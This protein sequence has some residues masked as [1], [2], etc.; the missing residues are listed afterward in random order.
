MKKINF[1]LWLA[2]ALCVMNVFSACD[3]NKEEED[4]TLSL[5][6]YV[7]INITRCE[8]VGERIVV[9]FN[10][11]NKSGAAI[12]SMYLQPSSLT[13]NLGKEYSTYDNIGMRIKGALQRPYELGPLNFQKDETKQFE[14]IAAGFDAG[15]TAKSIALTITGTIKDV[16]LENEKVKVSAKVVDN[17][18]LNNGIQTNDAGVVWTL[19]SCKRED[20]FLYVTYDIKNNTGS[21]FNTVDLQEANYMIKGYSFVAMDDLGQTYGNLKHVIKGS[22]NYNYWLSFGLA[23]GETKTIVTRI[24]NFDNSGNAT[25]ISICNTLTCDSYLFSDP[26]VRLINIPIQ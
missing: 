24:A 22:D 7:D 2:A 9:E 12:S 23:K 15:N 5:A 19:K 25:K 14:V 21:Q 3:K 18:V 26:I 17:R 4:N 16:D 11:R 8:R 10:M 13:D 6:K 20:G 1:M